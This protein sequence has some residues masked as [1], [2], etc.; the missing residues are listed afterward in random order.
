M[1][2][3]ADKEFKNLPTIHDLKDLLDT[4]QIS[5]NSPVNQKI[6]FTNRNGDT[7][8][9]CAFLL[10]LPVAAIETLL[11]LEADPYILNNQRCLPLH[12]AAIMGTDKESLEHL[13]KKMPPRF[14]AINLVN[15]KDINGNTAYQL[16]KES[17][18]NN[19]SP[20]VKSCMALLVAAGADTITTE[21][22]DAMITEASQEDTSLSSVL[23]KLASGDKSTINS[24]N[25][26]GLSPLQLAVSMNQVEIV[27]VLLE[28]GA[29]VNMINSYGQTALHIA[30]TCGYLEVIETLLTS[31][32]IDLNLRNKQGQ[33]AYQLAAEA[34]YLGQETKTCYME[35]L[36][37][38]GAN[39]AL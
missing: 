26:F 19:K 35:A 9:H 6:N 34:Y 30:V 18:K 36:K 38:A 11:E 28:R 21:I 8:L 2:E 10:R 25:S 12:I 16:L 13:L 22:S 17:Y 4:I 15:K 3:K 14:G 23:S 24:P 37:K 20:E 31:V 32:D 5:V 1:R 27:A 33:T 7:L 39:T 29:E